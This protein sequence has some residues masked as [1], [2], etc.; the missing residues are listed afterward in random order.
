MSGVIRVFL[1]DDDAEFRGVYRR[2]FTR[3]DGFTVTGE[4]G[5]GEDATRMIRALKPD[6]ALVDVQMPGGSGLDVVRATAENAT[7]VIVLT[8]F[9]LDEYVAEAIR[10]GAAGFLLKNASTSEVVAAVRVVHAGHSSLAPEVTARLMDQFALRPTRHAW[11]TSLRAMLR[12]VAGWR[13]KSSSTFCPV[14][15]PWSG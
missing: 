5:T 2:I 12:A 14:S 15:C 8:T 4:A 6:V 1:A 10:D 9:D 13:A 3:T 11:R 7:R